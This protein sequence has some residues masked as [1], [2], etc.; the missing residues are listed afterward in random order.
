MR[1]VSYSVKGGSVV[2]SVEKNTHEN[3]PEQPPENGE[4]VSTEMM[5]SS[6]KTVKELGSFVAE[7][8][9]I[10]YNDSIREHFDILLKKYGVSKKT[11]I[12]R[13]NIERGYAY[14]ILRGAKDAKRDKYIRLAIGIGLTLE[15]TQRLLTITRNGILYAKILRD[16]II[17]FCI[18]NHLDIMKLEWLLEEQHVNPLE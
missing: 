8:E 13:A 3:A 11:A 2:S 5:L 15:D 4:T 14:Q 12:A 9:K 6:L 7:N 1:L 17:I 10:F 16:A 18:N